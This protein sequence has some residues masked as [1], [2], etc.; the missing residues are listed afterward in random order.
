MDYPIEKQDHMAFMETMTP[1]YIVEYLDKHIIGQ[2]AAKKSVAVALRNRYRRMKLTQDV[3]ESITPKNIMMI[4]PTGVGKTEIARKLA[5]LIGAPFVKVEATKY[6]E[7]GYVGRDV[8]SMVRD[9]VASA[10]SIVKKEYAVSN[11]GKIILAANQHIYEHIL[12]QK[13]ALGLTEYDDAQI[14]I[15]LNNGEFD[16]KEI[17]IEVSPQ[18]QNPLQD[19]MQGVNIVGMG[20]GLPPDLSKLFG[21]DKKK[22][23]KVSVEK[24]RDIF[25]QEELEK[26]ADDDDIIEEAKWR[27]EQIGIVFIDE[28]DKIASSHETKNAGN[29]SRE[30][31]Q[32]DILPIVEGSLV[33][34]KYGVIDTTNILFIAAG[35]FY[36][37]KPSD[38]IPELQGRFPIRVELN[39]L[40]IDDFIKILSETENSLVEQYIK[41]ISTEGVKVT[42]DDNATVALAEIAY[43]MNTDAENIGAR[44]L[45][46]VMEKVFEELMFVAPQLKDSSVHIDKQYIT[47]KITDMIEDKET[48]KYIL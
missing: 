33:Q 48:Y 18:K 24:A 16:T 14:K 15:M 23:K 35:A 42:V 10:I 3:R 22:K 34:T 37:A 5:K 4:G 11:K 39:E 26:I 1:Q 21:G 31:V 17:E 44:R 38:L 29:I 20:G 46:T 12:R 36:V 47:D 41:L 8:E 32:R 27:A 25:Q 9:L 2:Q 19:M 40:S 13:T 43:Q 6:T 28:F 45:H 7:V 30:G